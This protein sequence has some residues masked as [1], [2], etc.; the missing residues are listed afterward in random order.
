MHLGAV[1]GMLQR[2][3][4]AGLALKALG[5]IVLFAEILEVGQR[6]DENPSKY[7]AGATSR[8]ANEAKHED[9]LRLVSAIERSEDPGKAALSMVVR[10]ALVRD[11]EPNSAAV[12]VTECNCSD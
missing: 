7:V 4:D 10:W 3:E 6:F 11:R 2:E 1:L 8:F 9:W 12:T 5:D